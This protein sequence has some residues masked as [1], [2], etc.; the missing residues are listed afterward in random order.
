[1]GKELD[2]KRAENKPQIQLLP[3]DALMEV[4]RV[5]SH[6]AGKHGAN[7]W[8]DEPTPWTERFGSMLRHTYAALN[9]Q[10]V[11]P[12]TGADGCYHLAEA[13]AQ[14]LFLLEYELKDLGEDDRHTGAPKLLVKLVDLAFYPEGYDTTATQFFPVTDNDILT[15]GG[16]L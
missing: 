3:V 11:D 15:S 9:G 2:L 13:I 6:G 5:I 14:G 1:M 4:A 8:R 10:D 16:G 7:S 12:D